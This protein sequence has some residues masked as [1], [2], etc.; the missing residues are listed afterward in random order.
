MR[1]AVIA[2]GDTSPIFESAQ[3]ILDFVAL[4]IELLVIRDG[5]F[6]ILSGRGTGAE[7]SLLQSIAEPICIIPA[8]SK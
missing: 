6:P 4:F 8:I 2:H 5:H 1:A 3:H 7:A